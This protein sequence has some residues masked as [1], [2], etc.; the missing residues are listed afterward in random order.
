MGQVELNF[1]IGETKKSIRISVVP[2]TQ[3]TNLPLGGIPLAFAVGGPLSDR[4]RVRLRNVTTGGGCYQR[5]AGV[6]IGLRRVFLYLKCICHL[7]FII[8]EGKICFPMYLSLSYVSFSE[9]LSL[10]LS[11]QRQ[12]PLLKLLISV[13][14]LLIYQRS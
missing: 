7:S 9:S 13:I 5:T 8:S 4:R 11:H 6:A 3:A 1:D 14:S 2:Y 12:K 10:S